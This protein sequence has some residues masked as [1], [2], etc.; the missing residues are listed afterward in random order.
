MSDTKGREAQEDGGEDGC[1]ALGEAGQIMPQRA[2]LGEK[3]RTEGKNSRRKYLDELW[4]K[5]TTVD[6]AN[7]ADLTRKRL[8]R[9]EGEKRRRLGQGVKRWI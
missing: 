7:P 1:G 9:E 5:E 3:K 4:K 6:S 8:E 2:P